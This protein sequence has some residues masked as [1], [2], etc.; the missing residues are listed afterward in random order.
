MADNGALSLYIGLSLII[1]LLVSFS[2]EYY[3]GVVYHELKD[4]PSL[5]K[6]KIGSLNGYLLTIGL[7]TLIVFVVAGDVFIKH[8]LSS[9]NPSAFRYTIMSVCTGI[10][11]A[12][13]KFYTNL[14]IHKEKPW[15][16]LGMNLIN[17]FTTV[18]FSIGI[19]KTFPLTLEGPIWGRFLSC[20][21]I[22]G[23]SFFALTRQYG[24][25][26]RTKYLI[27]TWRFC[28]PLVLTAIF[29][30][31]QI[32]SDRYIIKPLLFNQEVAIF[33][34]AVKFTLLV[35]FLLDGISSAMAPKVFALL[36][37]EDAESIKEVNK[38]YS[39]FNLAAL[40]LVPL[41]IVILPVI[42]PLFISSE[43]YLEAFL[44]FGII[45]AG[46]LTRGIQNLFLFPIQVF[47]KTSRLI[48][49]NGVAALAQIVIGYLM[50]YH[51]KLYGAAFTLNIVKV[52]LFG[53]YVYYCRDLISAQT[54][55]SKMIW[56]PLA[57][58]VIISVPELFLKQYGGQMHLVH[59]LE[60]TAIL[61]LTVL[62]YQSQLKEVGKWAWSTFLLRRT[63]D[64]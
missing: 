38:F 35:S 58:L 39:A 40:I 28:F 23:C 18:I 21:C 52:L 2:L 51:F 48:I 6:E 16:Y 7:F 8:Y 41:N 59:L 43:R 45:C 3:V 49:I 34:L 55:R 50:V 60:F 20:F 33:D 56:L 22:F 63:K 31:I 46:F 36:Q 11:N 37:H 32:Y 10:F 12:Y 4:T 57:G 24:L 53:L 62:V 47:R 30:W 9:Y 14:L 42:L 17:F 61:I 64:P 54:N 29:Q 44:Y 5:L 25:S 26:F 19:L 15:K 1:Q 13:F 27:P